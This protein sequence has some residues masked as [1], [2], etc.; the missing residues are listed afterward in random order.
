MYGWT[1]QRLKVYLTEGKIVKEE[2]PEWLRVG[3]IGGRGLN[4]R[5]L[6][7]EVKSG[8]DPL[9]PENVF[10][11][12]VGPLNGTAAPASGRFTVTA[13]APLTG[14]FGDGNGGGDFG[15]EL[16]FAGY[17]QIVFY[18]KSPTP[19]YLWIDDDQVELRD[20]SHLWGK[21]TWETHHLLVKELKKPEL[22]EISIGPAGENLVR[23]ATVIGD[24]SRSAGRGG[25]GAVMGS[26]NLK[27]VVVRGT[28]SVKIAR[29]KEFLEAVRYAL[30]KIKAA[31]F[32]PTFRQTGTLYLMSFTNE[33]GALTTRNNQTTWFEGADNLGPEAFEERYTV[34]HRGCFNCPV[35]CSHY[36]Q[37]KEGPYATYGEGVEFATIG[38]FGSRCGNDNLAPTLLAS[39]LCDQ[40]GMDTMSCGGAIA[41][42]ME[43]WQRGL[44]SSKGTDGLDLNW[45]NADAIIQLIRKIA[46]REGFGDILA[47]GSNLASRHIEGSGPYALTMKGMDTITSDPRVRKG[48]SLLLATSTR[49]ADHLRGWYPTVLGLREFTEDEGERLFGEVMGRERARSAVHAETYL[50]QGAVAFLLQNFEAVPNCLNICWFMSDYGGLDLD[51]MARLF[52]TATSIEVDGKGLERVGE[53]VYN[54]ERAFNV[55]EGLRR[56]DDSLPSRFFEEVPDGPGAGERIDPAKFQEML[57]EYYEFRGWDREGIPTAKKLEELNLGDIGGQIRGLRVWA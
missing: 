20:A 24:L 30:K 32:Y 36:Y 5:T 41:F 11:V 8:I 39:T 26:K 14:I 29:P 12:G 47:E 35:Q 38:A 7:D 33:M 51:D 42:A 48:W 17:D 56:K 2:T 31:S 28:G 16:K 10:M 34:R 15:A 19:V 43:A 23:F 45:G 40:L 1:G 53:R 46:Y 55:R 37:V 4:A 27:S 13:K 52:S 21:N 44:I 3:Y 54:I 49:G 25:M 22:H 9:G 50:G 6:F 57:D 18:G